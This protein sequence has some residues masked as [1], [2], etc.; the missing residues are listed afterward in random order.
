MASSNPQEILLSAHI[1]KAVNGEF[2]SQCDER[3][4]RKKRALQAA[5]ALWTQLPEDMQARLLKQKEASAGLPDLVHQIVDSYLDRWLASLPPA[6]RQQLEADAARS[7][8]RV[9]RKS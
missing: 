9:S 6:D 2:L 3:G 8:K 5:V 4:F 1:D 7:A